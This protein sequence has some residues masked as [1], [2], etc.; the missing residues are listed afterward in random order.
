MSIMGDPAWPQAPLTPTLSPPRGEGATVSSERQSEGVLDFRLVDSV[1]RL[2]PCAQDL[3][4]RASSAA[5]RSTPQ[6]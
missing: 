5:F 3:A 1:S 2:P 6:R 4:S